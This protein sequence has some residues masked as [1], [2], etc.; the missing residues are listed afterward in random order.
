MCVCISWTNKG[1]NRKIWSFPPQLILWNK[2]L[3]WKV[4]SWLSNQEIFRI[5]LDEAMLT[6]THEQFSSLHPNII[7]ISWKGNVILFSNGHIH[8][9]LNKSL[10]FRFLDQNFIYI[11]DLN[12]CYIPCPNYLISLSQLVVRI[13]RFRVSPLCFTYSGFGGLEV[14]CWP[15]VP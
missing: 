5:W 3:P 14:A 6:R 8:T 13:E 9:A 1:C 12:V 15:L 10:H 2:V 11:F 4:N 7:C